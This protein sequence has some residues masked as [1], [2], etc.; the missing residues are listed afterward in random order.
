[1]ILTSMGCLSFTSFLSVTRL[2]EDDKIVFVLDVD[3]NPEPFVLSGWNL[4]EEVYACLSY[5]DLLSPPA[6]FPY[7]KF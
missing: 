3:M 6:S 1:M 4:Q 5:L 7:D 2:L